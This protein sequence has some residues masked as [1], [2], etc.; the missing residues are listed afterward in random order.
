VVGLMSG[1]EPYIEHI[2]STE[3]KKLIDRIYK[4][5]PEDVLAQEAPTHLHDDIV[6]Q[7][8]DLLIKPKES[9][10]KR[11]MVEREV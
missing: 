2:E 10:D 11:N 8:D 9:T 3:I 1:E 5:K 6:E 7:I 4:S